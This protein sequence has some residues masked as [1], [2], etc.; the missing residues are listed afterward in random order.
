MRSAALVPTEPS[1]TVAP[2]EPL[3]RNHEAVAVAT[4]FAEPIAFAVATPAAAAPNAV[5]ANVSVTNSVPVAAWFAL[6]GCVPERISIVPPLQS[7]VTAFAAALAAASLRNG[8]VAMTYALPVAA[9]QPRRLDTAAAIS[10][11]LWPFCGYTF[12]TT[13]CRAPNFVSGVTYSG[14]ASP[15]M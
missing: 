14:P 12:T 4:A 15:N 6:L 2:P 9:A 8:L 5:A 1:N 11:S 10:T 13:F 7:A 3:A